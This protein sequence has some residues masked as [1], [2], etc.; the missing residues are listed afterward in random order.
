[1][2]RVYSGKQIFNPLSSVHQRYLEVKREY[3]QNCSV[4][5]CVTQCSQSQQSFVYDSQQTDSYPLNCS[6]PQ[7]SVLGPVEFA[8]YTE[9]IA[10]LLYTSDAADE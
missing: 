5:D 4:L 8:A 6:V 7:G 2:A 9:D 1:M 3:N 10:C